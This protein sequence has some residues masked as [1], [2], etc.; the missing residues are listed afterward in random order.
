MTEF[1]LLVVYQGTGD[2]WIGVASIFISVLFAYIV[3]AYLV[4]AKLSRPQTIV[5]TV[6]YT[7]FCLLLLMTLFGVQSRMIQ[8]ASEIYAL[9]PDRSLPG[10]GDGQ[11]AQVLMRD[12][13]TGILFMAYVAGLAFM[14]QS[15]KKA[16]RQ[17][18]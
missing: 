1:E 9:N 12:L 16:K 14:L 7:I 5:I 8:L 3:T 13:S 15:R 6:L 4:A 11:G 10:G 17:T 18:D 2:T